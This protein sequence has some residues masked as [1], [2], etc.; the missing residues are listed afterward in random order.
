LRRRN[1][2]I[3]VSLAVL[4]ATATEISARIWLD[5][6][7]R[8]SAQSLLGGHAAVGI[9]FR[10][11]LID[12]MAGSVPTLT[13]HATQVG[14]CNIQNVTV[15][16]TLNNAR[17]QNGQLAVSG[18]HASIVLPPA[19]ITTL[20]T[21]RLSSGM[22]ATVGLDPARNLLVLQIDGLLQVDEQ[23]ALKGNVVSFTPV[24]VGIGGFAAPGGMTGN[25]MQTAGFQQKLP[26][27]PLGMHPDAVQVT[28]E[29][30]VVTASGQAAQSHPAAHG[31][32]AATGL[33]TC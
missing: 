23:P 2:L 15:D 12:A 6:A 17:R 1:L 26:Q 20:L 10:P 29:G 24:S 28:S 14:V 30:V 19:V 16:A 25:L 33:H 8:A 3:A 27:L 11:A 21:K 7:L 32:T 5:S 4:L 18:S 31:T 22:Q 13:I 9:G